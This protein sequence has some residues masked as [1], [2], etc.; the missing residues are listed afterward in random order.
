[1]NQGEQEEALQYA[2]LAVQVAG[3]TGTSMSSRETCFTTAIK[4]DDDDVKGSSNTC[5][6][7]FSS[8]Q[9]CR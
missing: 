5:T 3:K 4:H 1:M 2:T 9:K 7:D 6:F 8:P